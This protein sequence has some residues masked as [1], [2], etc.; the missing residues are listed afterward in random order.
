MR[1]I[2]VVRLGAMGDILHALPAVASLRASGDVKIIWAVKPQ[3]RELLEGGGAADEIIEFRRSGLRAPA[4]RPTDA[5]RTV[6][7]SGRVHP[8]A[9]AVA[10]VD[11]EVSGLLMHLKSQAKH[12]NRQDLQD[13][14]DYTKKKLDLTLK[15]R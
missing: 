2:L 7:S 14:Q 1:T 3:F 5:L 6:Y 8:D 4:A 13:L 11:W 9:L 15:K 10:G 12:I